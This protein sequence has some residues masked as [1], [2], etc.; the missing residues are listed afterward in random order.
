[1]ADLIQGRNFFYVLPPWHFDLFFFLFLLLLLFLLSLFLLELY[2]QVGQFQLNHVINHLLDLIFNFWQNSLL[3]LSHFWLV[4][5]TCL[6]FPFFR[7]FFYFLLD[8]KDSLGWSISWEFLLKLFFFSQFFLLFLPFFFFL[9]FSQLLHDLQFFC[10]WWNFHLIF[11]IEILHSI[12]YF[13]EFVS[14]HKLTDPHSPVPQHFFLHRFLPLLIQLILQS[15]QSLL[16]LFFVVFLDL[17][18]FFAVLVFLENCSFGI[19]WI[20]RFLDDT[21]KYQLFFPHPVS[22]F[23]CQKSFNCFLNQGH[24][25][26]FLCFIIKIKIISLTLFLFCYLFQLS[27][28]QVG[29]SESSHNTLPSSFDFLNDTDGCFHV[30]IQSTLL[31]NNF[32]L[33]QG[34]F[35][36]IKQEF[37]NNLVSL[38]LIRWVKKDLPF[39]SWTKYLGIC[40]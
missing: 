26:I 17:S 13:W 18:H 12:R 30:G 35:L 10:C 23:S 33:R 40:I 14:F 22:H 7:V 28:L 38:F 9:C 21:Q 2:S 6:I 29:C 37:L 27:F 16:V 15:S 1:M 25:L 19:I 8:S 3:Y 5:R 20:L 11:F 24:L 31:L 4:F 39:L 34:C 32:F 36:Q